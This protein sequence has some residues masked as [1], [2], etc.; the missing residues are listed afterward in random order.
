MKG[1]GHRMVWGNDAPVSGPWLNNLP[2]VHTDLIVAATE[3]VSPTS[4]GG[5]DGTTHYCDKFF[6]DQSLAISTSSPMA[7]TV[8]KTQNPFTQSNKCTYIYTLKDASSQTHAPGFKLKSL[9]TSNSDVIFE[10]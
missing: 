2:A 6:V 5:H 3:Q 1:S 9:G 8:F 4:L 7:P 10:F